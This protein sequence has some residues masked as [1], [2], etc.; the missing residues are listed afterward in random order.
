MPTIIKELKPEEV[1]NLRE[2]LKV[3]NIV[4]KKTMAKLRK[5]GYKIVYDYS[6]EMQYKG[7]FIDIEFCIGDFCVSICSKN[8]HWLLE[9]KKSSENFILALVY[10]E[11]YK[12]RI[13][14]GE[15]WTGEDD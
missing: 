14:A 6:I 8:G 3:K 11:E 13:D 4:P 5:M 1:K 10:A 15:H 2:A 9:P 7:Y 12:K